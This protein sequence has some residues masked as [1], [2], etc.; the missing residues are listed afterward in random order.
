MSVVD[1][2]SSA[3]RSGAVPRLSEEPEIVKFVRIDAAQWEG[4]WDPEAYDPAQTKSLFDSH[5]EEALEAEEFVSA[6][7]KLTQGRR[8]K[9]DPPRRGVL[10][11]GGPHAGGGGSGGDP[12]LETAG[13]KHSRDRA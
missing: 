9:T 8:L 4:D 2:N 12:G 6:D 5:I 3:P 7:A 1:R 10:R 13:Q 11:T